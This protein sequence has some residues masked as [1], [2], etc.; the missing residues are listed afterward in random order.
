MKQKIKQP[1]RFARIESSLKEQVGFRSWYLPEP[2]LELGRGGRAVDP[3]SG[4]ALYGPWDAQ[5]E[6]SLKH[7][8]VGIIGTGDTISAAT[9]WLQA[10]K[11]AVAP[12]GAEVDPILFPSFPGFASEF[13]FNCTIEAPKRLH[14]ILSSGEVAR[15]TA[16]SDR[17]QAIAAMTAVIRQRMEALAEKDSPPDVILIALPEEVRAVAGGGRKIGRKKKKQKD[18]NQLS[19][20][21][22]PHEVHSDEIPPRTLYRAIKAEGMRVKIPTQMAWPGTFTGGDGVQDDATR[23]WNFFTALYYKAGGVP[24]R[25]TGLEKDTCYIGITFFRPSDDHTK[26]QTSMAQAFSDRGDGLILRGESFQWDVRRQG[27]PHLTRESARR[28]VAGVIEQ[29]TKHLR[30]PPTRVVLHKSS[31]FTPDEI[32]GIREAT[33]TVHYLDLLAIGRSS[34]RFLRMGNEPPLRGT[35]MEVGHRKYLFYTGGYVPFLR[36]YPGLRIPCPLHVSHDYGDGSVDQVLGEILA[37]SKLNWNSA[38][39]GSANPITVDFS[40]NVGLI[41]SEMPKDIEPQKFY[42]YY[43]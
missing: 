19:F 37:L 1:T 22:M 12:A 20:L 2:E 38:A 4:I 9:S 41:L 14:E 30:R 6:A 11:D 35:A 18:P 23:A 10:C 42:R 32:S 13:G 7:I 26:L 17:D 16:A 24:W 28:L 39:F 27:P 21:D 34:I 15:C 25:V 40:N 29:Y 31:R 5:D 8:R 43:M 33:S 36:V 3:K